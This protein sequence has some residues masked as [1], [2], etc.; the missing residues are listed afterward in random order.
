MTLGR[1]SAFDKHSSKETEE[2]GL[3]VFL[4]HLEI[5]LPY[6]DDSFRYRLLIAFIHPCWADDKHSRPEGH[7][8]GAA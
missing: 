3:L 8:C 7:G 1:V 5:S 2:S 6:A 4:I